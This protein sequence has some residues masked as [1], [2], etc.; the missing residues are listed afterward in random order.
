MNFYTYIQY[1]ILV[2]DNDKRLKIL[3]SR[4]VIF[5]IA[6]QGEWQS[7]FLPIPQLLNRKLS[8]IFFFL[9]Q[10]TKPTKGQQKATNH[11]NTMD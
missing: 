11:C 8:N 7:F 2:V 5:K 6:T 3:T 1:S 9:I 4:T 10:R